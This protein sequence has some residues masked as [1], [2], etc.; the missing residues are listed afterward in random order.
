[1]PRTP[2]ELLDDCL[3]RLPVT[4]TALKAE[5]LEYCISEGCIEEPVYPDPQ[6][7]SADPMV[8]REYVSNTPPEEPPEEP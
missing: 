2:D 4:D 5:I 1:M 3:L 6:P 8:D 7:S